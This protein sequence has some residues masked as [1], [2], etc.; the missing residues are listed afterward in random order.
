[1]HLT[2]VSN[3]IVA[4][5]IPAGSHTLALQADANTSTNADDR[6]SITVLELPP[7]TG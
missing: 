6:C 4:P 5:G 1:M 3:D 7:A 2:M